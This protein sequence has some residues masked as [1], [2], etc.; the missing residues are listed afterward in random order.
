M[1]EA[2]FASQQITNTLYAKDISE[3]R[4]CFHED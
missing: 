3:L 1:Q 4:V 2:R